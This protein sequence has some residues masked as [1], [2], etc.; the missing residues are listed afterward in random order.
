MGG[1]RGTALPGVRR[2]PPS[3]SRRPPPP[4][5][6]SSS[7]RLRRTSGGGG[8]GKAPYSGLLSVP[9]VV[10]RSPLGEGELEGG[11]YGTTMDEGEVP[12][13]SQLR[14][15][16]LMG[17]GAMEVDDWAQPPAGL[18][19]VHNPTNSGH[20]GSAEEGLNISGGGRLRPL[21][22]GPNQKRGKSANAPLSVRSL[23]QEELDAAISQSTGGAQVTNQLSN[24]LPDAAL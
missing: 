3:T 19:G 16:G 4:R 22:G 7:V 12:N 14:A 20:L 18:G 10:T 9:E 23:S 21:G 17:G 24:C 6:C 2:G 11:V 15:G 8:P 1:A 13:D 5:Q